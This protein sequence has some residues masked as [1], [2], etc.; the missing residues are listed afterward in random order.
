[1]VGE[2]LH[3]LA[4]AAPV[5]H[6]VQGESQLPGQ[7]FQVLVDA[8]GLPP[9]VCEDGA[10][11]DAVERSL[12]RYE[13]HDGG[14][15]ASSQADDGKRRFGLHHASAS[16]VSSA[17]R[18]SA[19]ASPPGVKYPSS[20]AYLTSRDR[21][22][23]KR[24][25]ASGPGLEKTLM[26]P[27]SEASLRGLPRLLC[28]LFRVVSFILRSRSGGW[29]AAGLSTRACGWAAV[30]RPFR[31]LRRH[32]AVSDPAV[33]AVRLYSSCHGTREEMRPC[34]WTPFLACPLKTGPGIMRVLWDD[35]AC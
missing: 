15:D 22:R 25:R 10:V 7:P 35:H 18:S 2:G 8:G 29:W 24:S 27:I 33:P 19:G 4:E 30:A 14:L 32:P 26:T 20:V 5:V 31:R 11:G 3:V 17:G 13:R 9:G 23:R 12:A 16:L 28:S 1:M 6:D 21:R 34:F